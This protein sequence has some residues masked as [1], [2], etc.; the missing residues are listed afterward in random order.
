MAAGDQRRCVITSLALE[1]S[2]RP[3]ITIDLEQPGALDSLKSK[4]F[5]IKEGATFHMKAHFR[6][7]HEVLSGLKYLQVVRRKGIPV[8]KDEEMLVCFHDCAR[9]AADTMVSPR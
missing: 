6:V 4:P 8:A 5:T 3:D 1:V 7:Q 9:P 2:G